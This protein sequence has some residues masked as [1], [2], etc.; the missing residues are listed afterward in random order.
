MSEDLE[1]ISQESLDYLN[2]LKD[3]LAKV[4]IALDVY[5]QWLTKFYRL[6]ERD[7][8]YPDGRI[9]REESLE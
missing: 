6:G 1:S 5:K 8:V 9:E 7:K 2:E 4:Q 3:T